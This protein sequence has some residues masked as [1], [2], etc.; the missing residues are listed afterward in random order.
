MHN[1]LRMNCVAGQ[2]EVDTELVHSVAA[3]MMQLL[4]FCVQN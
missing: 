3:N 1:R 4:S 2:E